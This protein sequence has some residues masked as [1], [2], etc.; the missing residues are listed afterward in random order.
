MQMYKAN[1]FSFNVGKLIWLSD[2]LLGS[3]WI[4]LVETLLALPC[5]VPHFYLLLSDLPSPP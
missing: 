5:K 4:Y 2:L 1:S 3:K